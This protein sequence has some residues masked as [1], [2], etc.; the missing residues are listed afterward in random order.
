M[1]ELAD[2]VGMTYGGLRT[3][4]SNG[5]S[6]KDAVEHPKYISSSKAVECFG[7]RYN[8]YRDLCI[9]LGLCY[10]GLLLKLKSGKPLE[11]VVTEM[12]EYLSRANVVIKNL[13]DVHEF[14][15]L[16]PLP[17]VII[18]CGVCGRYVLLDLELAK[19]FSHSDK[20]KSYEW[21]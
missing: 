1:E 17:Y 18:K 3:R 5:M 10:N 16:S 6:V 7:V 12:L 9:K 14:K 4:L 20:C 8:S 19:T 2:A 11:Q 15:L 13:P 21:K